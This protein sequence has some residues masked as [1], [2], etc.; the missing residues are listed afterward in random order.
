MTLAR[1]DKLGRIPFTDEGSITSECPE[2][3]GTFV[4]GIS[5]S[6]QGCKNSSLTIRNGVGGISDLGTAKL[7]FVQQGV[8]IYVELHLKQILEYAVIPWTEEN[9]MDIEWAFHQDWAPAHGEKKPLECCGSNLPCFWTKDVWPSN[10]P[11]LSP[12]N[13]AA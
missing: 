13:I 11:A 5:R 12:L 8:E 9:A 6:R 10:S 7:V 1:V 3:A 2:S 4:E